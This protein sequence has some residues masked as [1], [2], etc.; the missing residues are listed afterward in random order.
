[1]FYTRNGFCE[2]AEYAPKKQRMS[3]WM[4][5]CIYIDAR[6]RI[7]KGRQ[8]AALSSKKEGEVFYA[9]AGAATD[10]A[11]SGASTATGASAVTLSR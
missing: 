3:S 9:T 2:C 1:M 10:A 4:I 11:T 7:E 5:R 6:R 8:K